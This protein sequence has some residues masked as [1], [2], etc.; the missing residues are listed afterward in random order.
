MITIEEPPTRLQDLIDRARAALRAG[1]VEEGERLARV[2]LA[3]D[4]VHADGYNVLALAFEFR[5][6]RTGAVDLL[7]AG[8]AVEPTHH[9][10]WANLE[11]LTTFPF[12][13]V[14]RYGDES[15]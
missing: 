3:A 8:L 4:P 7:R 11:R 6:A 9:A 2:V 15:R 13:G 14:P 1:D 5:G 12:T 10:A